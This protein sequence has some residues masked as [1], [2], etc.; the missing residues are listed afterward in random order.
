MLKD[1]WD[2]AGGNG[3]SLLELMQKATMWNLPLGIA[4]GNTY[5][6]FTSIPSSKKCLFYWWE[7]DGTFIQLEPKFIQF[8]AYVESE[9]SNKNYTNSGARTV[10]SSIV[11]HDLKDLAPA[12]HSFIQDFQFDM[13]SVRSV[14]LDMKANGLSVEETV[15]QWLKKNEA[16]PGLVQMMRATMCITSCRAS[17]RQTNKKRF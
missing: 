16:A 13:D 1:S 9:W 12:I 7:P 2:S 4:V 11:S 5:M 3:W 10:V 15:R 14:L 6:D 17:Q 8:P